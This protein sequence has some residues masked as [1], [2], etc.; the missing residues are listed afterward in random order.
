VT[1]DEKEESRQG[2]SISKKALGIVTPG[3]NGNPR[4]LRESFGG[5]AENI[6]SCISYG[7]KIL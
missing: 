5:S 3:I 1:R 4:D 2:F 7:L 6:G